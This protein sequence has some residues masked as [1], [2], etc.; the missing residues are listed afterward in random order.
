LGLIRIP[1]NGT[2]FLQREARKQYKKTAKKLARIA[3]GFIAID[4]AIKTEEAGLA[5]KRRE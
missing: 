5:K 2:K 1:P 3:F 4:N